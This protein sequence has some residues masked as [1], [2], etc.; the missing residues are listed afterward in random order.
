MMKKLLAVALVL[1]LLIP[2]AY[3][4]DVDTAVSVYND[5]ARAYFGLGELNNPVDGTI[6]VYAVMEDGMCVD[7]IPNENG[8]VASAGCFMINARSDGATFLTTCACLLYTLDHQSGETDLHSKLLSAYF[9]CRN[10][11]DGL[12]FHSLTSSGAYLEIKKN[13]GLFEFFVAVNP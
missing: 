2:C 11:E 7:F 9:R 6:Y 8:Q 12:A 3:A 13:N 4:M 10:R 1:C 5:W